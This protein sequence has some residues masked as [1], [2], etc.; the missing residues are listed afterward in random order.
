VSEGLTFLL[1][2]SVSILSGLLVLQLLVWPRRAPAVVRSQLAGAGSASDASSAHPLLR[3]AA[4]FGRAGW[5]GGRYRGVS[6]EWRA[7]VGLGNEPASVL[8]GFH[9]LC[10]ALSMIPVLFLLLALHVN[11]LAL[12][13]IDLLAGGCFGIVY[14]SAFFRRRRNQRDERMARQLTRWIPAVVTRLQSGLELSE[15]VRQANEALKRTEPRRPRSGLTD[16][17]MEVD[18]MLREQAR[19][20]ASQAWLGLAERCHQPTVRYT[21]RALYIVVLQD[22]PALDLLAGM[23]EAI[24]QEIDTQLNELAGRIEQVVRVLSVAVAFFLLTVTLVGMVA[25]LFFH[26]F[27]QVH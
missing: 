13:A 16:L 11:P 14:P 27:G 24:L 1:T 5:L 21:M 7:W 8:V 15:A 17:Y 22:V 19:V 20:P 2:L 3:L 9:L 18:G 4:V 12:V 10:G 25:S 6:P 23:E 26:G